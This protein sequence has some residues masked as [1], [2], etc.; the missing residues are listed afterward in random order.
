MRWLVSRTSK[1]IS[2]AVVWVLILPLIFFPCFLLETSIP[3]YFMSYLV[4]FK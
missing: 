1:G 3:A 4:P 2:K